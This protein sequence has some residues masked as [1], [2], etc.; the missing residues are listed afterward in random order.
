[1]KIISRP[2]KVMAV[3]GYEGTPPT[4]YKFKL[5][6]NSEEITIK[7][8]KVI[9]MH[10]RRDGGIDKVIYECQGIVNGTEKRFELKYLPKGYKWLLYKI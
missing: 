8:D 9:A 5:I 3:F 7:I 4:P 10:S 6:E 1:M 2:I